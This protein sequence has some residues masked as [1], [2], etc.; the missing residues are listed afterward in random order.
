MVSNSY[1]NYTPTNN[2]N[3]AVTFSCGKLMKDGVY[4]YICILLKSL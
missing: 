3:M 4:A 1:I 2:G